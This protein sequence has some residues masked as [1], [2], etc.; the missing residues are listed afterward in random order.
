MPDATLSSRPRIH[1][2]SDRRVTL[3]GLGRHGGGMGAARFLAD[4]GASVTISDAAEASALSTA[5]GALAGVPIQAMHFG[6]HDERDF[7][8]AEIVVVNPAV[9][10]DHPC[11]RVAR[12][13]GARLTSEIELF[14]ERCPARVIGVSG[15]NGKSTTATML[16]EILR[17]EG[18]RT[19]LGGNIGG[20]LLDQLDQMRAGDWVVLELSSFQLAHLNRGT[21]LPEISVITNCTPNHLDWHGTFAEY[22]AAKRRLLECSAVVLNADDPVTG[23]WC[24]GGIGATHAGWDLGRIPKL[25]VPGEHNRHNAACAAAAAELVGVI[26]ETIGRTLAGFGGLEHRIEWVAEVNGLRFYN[27]SKATS[28]SATMAALAAIDGPVWL[29]AGGASKG[30]SFNDLAAA[31]VERTRGVAVFGQAGDLL[32]S[33]IR[34]RDANHPAHGCETLAAALPWCV[35]RSNTGDAILLSPACASFD[36]FDGFEDRGRRFVEMVRRFAEVERGY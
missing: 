10:P 2:W 16:A 33:S 8:S 17:S 34:A 24:G 35:E 11:L 27:D 5:I 7:R 14:L 29:L 3:M 23:K 31:A 22:A 18:L 9:R 26:E 25:L 13:A 15:S 36:Q 19:W 28:P 6:G 30:T 12:E 4:Q 32:R 1:E 21:P 20:S